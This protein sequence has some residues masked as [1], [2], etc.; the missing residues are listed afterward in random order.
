M[1]QNARAVIRSELF[2][3]LQPAECVQGRPGVQ[4]GLESIDLGQT[5]TVNFL[6]I[7]KTGL[8]QRF[9]FECIWGAGTALWPPTN[10]DLE[11]QSICSVAAKLARGLQENEANAFLR[12]G[13]LG[14]RGFPV[15]QNVHIIFWCL[16]SSLVQ[17]CFPLRQTGKASAWAK[18]FFSRKTG[19]QNDRSVKGEEQVENH[20]KLGKKIAFL[21]IQNLSKLLK[22]SVS[23]YLEI[24]SIAKLDCKRLRRDGLLLLECD[25]S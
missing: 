17:N 23:K 11:C 9:S 4:G 13:I 24:D 10:L 6:G 25:P 12:H 3:S 20:L 1:R 21:N 5:E 14:E 7:M 15:V 16:G 18:V 22:S 8:N 2:H 19:V